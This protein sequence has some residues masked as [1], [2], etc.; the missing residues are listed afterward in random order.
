MDQHAVPDQLLSVAILGPRD[1]RSRS[2]T[3]YAADLARSLNSLDNVRVTRLLAPPDVSPQHGKSDT[4][5][6]RSRL[7]ST[8][9]KTIRYARSILRPWLPTPR[10]LRTD[11]D[12]YHAAFE[13]DAYLLSALPRQRTIVTCHDLFQFS[14]EHGALLTEAS[15]WSSPGRALRKRQL[16]N[17]LAQAGHIA[18]ISEQTRREVIEHIPIDPQRVSVV[19]NGLAA[20][21]R[22]LAPDV[23]GSVRGSL[24]QAEHRLIQVSSGGHPRKN[25][26]AALRVLRQLVDRGL[27][28]QLLNVGQPVDPPNQQLAAELSVDQRIVEC[29]AVDDQ[30]LV[31]LYNAADVLLF[32]SFYEGFGWPPLEAMACGTPAVVSNIPVFVEI[33]EDDAL[34]AAPADIDALTSQVESIL[35]NTKLAA[36]LVQRGL[37]RAASYRW[38]RTA[39]R[40][41]SIYRKMLSAQTTSAAAEDGTFKRIEAG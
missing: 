30:R 32:P 41:E 24:P 15:R 16:R 11:V 25:V 23:V 13:Y 20:H 10:E 34:S 19:R 4:A 35:T 18:C 28:V 27:D 31:Q 22:V 14:T 17:A 2:I 39:T 26:P 8:I 9:R 6:P 29:G 3:R 37:E 33:L 7:G 12:I 36:S 5:P 40:F 38:E 21:F 1:N